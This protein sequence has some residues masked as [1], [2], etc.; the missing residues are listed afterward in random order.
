MYSYMCV[1][2]NGVFRYIKIYR[3]IIFSPQQFVAAVLRT[4]D[5]KKLPLLFEFFME[6][7]RLKK[8]TIFFKLKLPLSLL[9]LIKKSL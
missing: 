9:F 7:E 4:A 5:T 1:D 6:I 3:L 8:K 2:V